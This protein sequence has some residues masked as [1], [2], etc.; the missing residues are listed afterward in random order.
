MRSKIKF[1]NE[2]Q[3]DIGETTRDGGK[4]SSTGRFKSMDN[5]NKKCLQALPGVE[6][7][8]DDLVESYLDTGKLSPN[9][10][11]LRAFA[12]VSFY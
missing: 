12:E 8:R 1:S 9:H 3:S 2:L 6:K 7:I 5:Q 11:M 10:V 4:K